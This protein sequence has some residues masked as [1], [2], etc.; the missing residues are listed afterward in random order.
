MQAGMGTTAQAGTTNPAVLNPTAGA[1]ETA[2]NVG[3]GMTDRRLL[4][5]LEGW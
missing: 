2:Y 4:K 3:Q 5:N 1:T